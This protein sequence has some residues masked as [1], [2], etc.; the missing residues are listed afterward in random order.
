MF[1]SRKVFYDHSSTVFLSFGINSVAWLFA[2][3]NLKTE[4]KAHRTASLELF[5][6]QKKKEDVQGN[7]PLIIELLEDLESLQQAFIHRGRFIPGFEPRCPCI[8]LNDSKDEDTI[9]IATR[10]H[11]L[12]SIQRS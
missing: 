4:I 9:S 10:T 8:Q 11:Q 5:N 1:I 12:Y 2:W 7:L 6:L 3:K